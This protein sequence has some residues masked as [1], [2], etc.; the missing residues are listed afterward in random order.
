MFSGAEKF[1]L[2]DYYLPSGVVLDIGGGED[3]QGR[4]GGGGDGSVEP[5][6]DFPLAGGV[7]SVWNRLP[8]VSPGGSAGVREDHPD[9]PETPGGC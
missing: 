6:V 4:G 3:R 9:V 8:S 2:A 1:R 7:V 5:A